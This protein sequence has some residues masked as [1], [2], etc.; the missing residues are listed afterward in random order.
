[1][2]E[3]RAIENYLSDRAIRAVKGPKYAALGAYEKLST[4]E[5]SWSKTE[6]AAIAREMTIAELSLNDLGQF[7]RD[8]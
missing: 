5:L 4:A 3:R 6:S 1:M 7:L 8:I 2:L